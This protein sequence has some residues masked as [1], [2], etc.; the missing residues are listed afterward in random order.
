ML[1]NY[2]NIVKK[3]LAYNVFAYEKTVVNLYLYLVNYKV[4]YIIS[5]AKSS[6]FFQNHPSV[7]QIIS[8]KLWSFMKYLGF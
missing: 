4:Y 7:N 3:R 8:W 6:V 1:L 5:N 2:I